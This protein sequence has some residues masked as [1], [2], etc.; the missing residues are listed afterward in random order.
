M[1]HLVY[2]II[3]VLNFNSCK[4][5]KTS[6]MDNKIIVPEMTKE[7][8][9]FD[10]EKFQI[11]NTSIFEEQID[12]NYIVYSGDKKHAKIKSGFSKGIYFK[13]SYFSI[14][15][16]YFP[17][18][19]IEIKGITYNNGSEYGIWYEFDKEG[20][21]IKE[22]NTDAGYNFGWKDVFT[23]CHKNNIE[24]EKGYPKRGGI[25]TE[26]YKNEEN[27]KKIWTISYYKIKKEEYLEVILDGKTGKELQRRA[28][29]F[30]GN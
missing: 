25:K 21:L 30:I 3:I 10:I 19:M 9:E 16:N 11:K 5:Q 23:Y 15:K 20:K 28:L 6:K 17:N 8:E 29:E 13:G 4:A 14:T 24:L 12:N 2:L 27:G 26:I 18:G 22:I 1:K 7:F